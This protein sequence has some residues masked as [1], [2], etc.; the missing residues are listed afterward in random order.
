MFGYWFLWTSICISIEWVFVVTKHMDHHNGWTFWH[1]YIADWFLF[2][3]FYQFHKWF[4][5]ELLGTDMER[6]GDILF[7][8]DTESRLTYCRSQWLKKRGIDPQKVIGKI[9]YDINELCKDEE[10]KHKHEQTYKRVLN[11]EHLMFEW[12]M[13]LQ[14]KTYSFH[15]FLSPI[16]DKS[17]QIIGIMGIDYEKKP[18]LRISFPTLA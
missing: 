8:L 5:L 11:G 2:W 14:D 7:I 10:D 1:S 17:G 4:Q 15:S 18:K 6:F 9:V 12:E 13:Y 3:V 16:R